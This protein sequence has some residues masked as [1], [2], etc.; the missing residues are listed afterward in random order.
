MSQK[1]S[2]VL[3]NRRAR[4]I[5]TIEVPKKN[6]KGKRKAQLRIKFDKVLVG[7][8]RRRRAARAEEL[9]PQLLWACEIIENTPPK[10]EEK[11]H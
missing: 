10:E 5:Q 11:I 2:H 4:A 6:G 1:I 3:N 7:P 9:T 8:T